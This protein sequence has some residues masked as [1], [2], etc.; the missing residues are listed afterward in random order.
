MS[1]AF[2][3]Q[4]MSQNYLWSDWVDGLTDGWMDE[5]TVGQVG[6]WVDGWMDK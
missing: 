3:R 5:Q 2:N 1:P 4:G 6:G